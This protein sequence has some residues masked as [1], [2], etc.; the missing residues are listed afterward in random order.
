[1]TMSAKQPLVLVLLLALIVPILA[2]C[3]GTA[4][5]SSATTAPA[6]PATAA[7]AAAPTAAPAADATAA[8][9]AEATAAPTGGAM[10][11]LPQV[12]PASVTGDMIVAGSS[13]VYPLTQ[14]IA[15]DFKSEGYAGQITIDSI[16]S[17]AGFERFC[18]GETDISNASR[19]IKEEETANCKA[20]GIEPLEFRVGTDALTIVVSNQNDFVSNLTLEQLAKIFSGEAKTWKDVDAGWPADAIQ[21]FSPGTDSGTFDYFAEKVFDADYKKDK[22]TAYAKITQAPGIQLSENDNVLVQGVEGSPNAIGYFG[23]AY[24]KENAGKLKAVSVEGVEPNEQTAESGKYPIAR[25]LFIY[26]AKTIMQ[27]KPQ[28]ASFI[29]YYLSYVNDV[30]DEVGYF[31]ASAEAIGGAKQNLLDAAVLKN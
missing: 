30:I 4:T 13:T 24:F 14:K 12:D 26:S 10:V 22:K 29:A 15:E 23:Y 19:A 31:P 16:G 3:G 2:A 17:G 18:K 6:A 8:P 20:I 25:P 28:V 7:P 9:A 5:T 1:M 27:K 11:A 21:L